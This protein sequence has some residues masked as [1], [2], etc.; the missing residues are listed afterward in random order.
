MC[1]GEQWF[2]MAWTT[3]TTV[4]SSLSTILTLCHMV[5]FSCL[6]VFPSVLTSWN[7]FPILPFAPAPSLYLMVLCTCGTGL[8]FMKMFL[9][10]FLEPGNMS[11]YLSKGQR[12]EVIVLGYLCELSGTTKS[13]KEEEDRRRWEQRA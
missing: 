8:C 12:D 9:Y 6:R 3:S 2:D 11:P 1:S 13:S 10:Q 5:Q 7:I 4:A